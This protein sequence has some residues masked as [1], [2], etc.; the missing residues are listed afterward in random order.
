MHTSLSA[1]NG[2]NIAQ[3]IGHY[4]HVVVDVATKTAYFSGI[5]GLLANGDLQ[6][7]HAGAQMSQIFVNLRSMLTNLGCDLTHV[8]KATVMVVDLERNREVI[9][10]IYANNFDTWR[11]ARS[12]FG[13]AALPAGALVEMEVIVKI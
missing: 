4:S 10:K 5:I 12:M 11:P 6:N 8:I 1:V 7:G 3:P 2:E 13:V 9:N